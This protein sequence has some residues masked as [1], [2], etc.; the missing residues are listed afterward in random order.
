MDLTKILGHIENHEELIKQIESELGKEYV[1][2]SEF[3]AKNT[4]LKEL[5]K[6]LSDLNESLT[7]ATNEKSTLE[8]S[9]ADLTAKASES[10][11]KALKSQIAYETG[12]PIE[13]AGRLTGDDEAALRA[14]ADSLAK[15]VTKTQAPPLK[16]TED[17]ASGSDDP[18]RALARGIQGE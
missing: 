4:S 14:D 16:T 15:L 3:N 10:E 11:L 9:I 7:A 13:L 6:Q 5:E 17:P 1:P 18:Y 12:L 8:Q 2:R